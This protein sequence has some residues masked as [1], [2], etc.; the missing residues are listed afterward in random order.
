MPRQIIANTAAIAAGHPYGAEAGIE[1]LRGGGNAIDAAVAAM[2]ALSV[3]IPGSVGL[4]GYGGSA[5]VY[6]TGSGGHGAGSRTKVGSRIAAADS[7]ESS[8]IAVDF[9]SCAPLGFR[10]GLVTADPESS[11]Y[12]ARAVTVPAVVAGLERILREF[13]TKSWRVVSQPAMQFAE[14]GFEFDAEHERHFNRCAAKFDRQ[15]LESLFP[16]GGVPAIGQR[17]RQPQLAKLLEHLAADG[18]LSFYDGE[19]PRLIVRYLNQRGGILTEEDFCSYRPQIVEA[20][21]TTCRGFELHTPP[22]PSGGITSLGIVR[23]VESFFGAAVGSNP[24]SEDY[25]HVLAEAMKLGWQ[26]RENLLG[27]PDFVSVPNDEL[28]SDAAAAARCARIRAQRSAQPKDTRPR[29]DLSPS[30]EPG[31][32]RVDPRFDSPH[33]ANVIASDGDGNLISMTATQG[34]MY[35]SHL[36]VDGMGLVLNHGM[37][38]FNY[39]PGHPNAPSPGKRMLHNMAPMIGLRDDRPVFAFGMPGGP[40]IVS[41]TAQL[42]LDAIAF[43]ATPAASI[44]APRLHTDGNGP[45]LVSADMPASVIADLEARGHVVRRE[46]DMGGPVNVLAVDSQAGKFDIA[47]GES[48]GAVAGL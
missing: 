45:L 32:L 43:G 42:A 26:E 30:S 1:M 3:V 31:T 29:N 5:I 37:S 28:L 10:E 20:I 17:W 25:F 18:P 12:G 35:G 41:V 24:W 23:T 9:D 13:G 21:H 36:V 44:A 27:D 46:E 34:W 40:K 8:V 19:I 7:G 47:S 33:T 15:S 4:G 2:L 14:D 16:G 6:L 11:Y 38:R 48:T 39:S 22:A